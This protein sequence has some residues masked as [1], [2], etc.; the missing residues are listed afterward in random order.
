VGIISTLGLTTKPEELRESP[1]EIR[2]KE[3]GLHYLNQTLRDFHK[4]VKGKFRNDYDWDKD[5]IND[6]YLEAKDGT[7]YSTHSKDHPK[8]TNDLFTTRFYKHQ[9]GE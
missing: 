6:V 5:G 8:D 3:G 7:V 9:R 2:V 4:G 1:K